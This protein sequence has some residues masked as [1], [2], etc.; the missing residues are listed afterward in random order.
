MRKHTEREKQKIRESILHSEKHK[1]AMRN[2]DMTY[3]IERN[4]QRKGIKS[5]WWGRKHTSDTKRKISEHRKGGVLH[6]TTETIDKIRKANLGRKRSQEARINIS[7]SKIG[8]RNP[9]FGK[10]P[11]PLIHKRYKQFIVQTP[12]QGV[13]TLRS[14]YEKRLYDYL[15]RTQQKFLYEPRAFHIMLK[16]KITTYTPD[17]YLIEQA[18]YVEVKGWL[19]DVHKQK[20]ECLAEQHNIK[21]ELVGKNELQILAELKNK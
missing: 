5:I 14:S 18:S 1:E 16:G 9:N 8:N 2:R 12:L 21:V 11:S 19:R 7:K 3:L 20:I 17:F 10:T 13:K 15:M 6:H 4:R